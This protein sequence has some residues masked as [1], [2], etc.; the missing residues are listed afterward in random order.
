MIGV[1]ARPEARES[2]VEFFE[3]FK[4]PW[5]FCRLDGRYAVVIDDGAAR[6][7]PAARLVVVYGSQATAFDHAH[8]VMPVREHRQVTLSSDGQPIPLYGSCATFPVDGASP[9]LVVADTGDAAVSVSESGGTTFV[10]VGYDLF[11]EI[12]QLLTKGQPAQHAAIP[13]LERHIAFLRDCILA[14]GVPLVEIPPVPAGF[15]FTACLTHDVDHPSIRRHRLDHTMLGFLSRALIGS[16]VDVCT[17]HARPRALW[18]NW[19]AALRLPL[20]HLGLAKDFWAQFDRYLEIDGRAT[21]TFFVIP[22]AGRPG[23][24]RNGHAPRRRAS[25][26]GASD[27]APT[28]RHLRQAGAEISL[29]GIDAWLDSARGRDER[30]A[31]SRATGSAPDG[32]RMHWLF[33]ADDAPQRLEEAGFSY[34]STFGYN[35]TVGLRAGTLQAFKPLSARHLLELPLNVMDTALFYRAYRHLTPGAARGA[36]EPLLAAAE[37]Y[38][39]IFTVNWH[40]RSLAAER[41]WGDVYADLVQTLEH[42]QAWLPTMGQAAAWC[43]QRRSIVFEPAPGTEAVTTKTVAPLRPDLPPLLIRTHRP[44]DTRQS[45]LRAHRPSRFTDVRFTGPCSAPLVGVRPDEGACVS[46]ISK[47]EVTH[48]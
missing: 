3:L 33:W 41:L 23:L 29:H 10:R 48:A 30:D 42:R 44:V 21:S 17:G 27:I 11:G 22:A 9:G 45:G 5:E 8:E 16:V 12:R 18:Q 25:V 43:R 39:G 31:V 28:L 26:Y 15:R 24:T 47:N 40:D 14:A 38:G 37:R 4:T 6:A 13:T 32:T 1:L 7:R 46:A 35:D 34:D 36:I 19:A 20:V 2:V